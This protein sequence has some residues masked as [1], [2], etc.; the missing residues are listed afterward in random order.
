MNSMLLEFDLLLLIFVLMVAYA[1]FE[2]TMRVFVYLN[3]L[4]K[5]FLIEIQKWFMKRKMKRQLDIDYEQFQKDLEELRNAK[6]N[7]DKD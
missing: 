4:F 2:G 1:G 6:R 7:H 5:T 3:L